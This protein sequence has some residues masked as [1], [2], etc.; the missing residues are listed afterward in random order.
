MTEFLLIL[1]GII[2]VMLLYCLSESL[3]FKTTEYIVEADAMNGKTMVLLSDLHC[4]TFGRANERLIRAVKEAGPDLIV[5]SGDLINGKNAKEFDYAYSFLDALKKLKVPVYYSFGN[6]ELKIT[7]Y[8]DQK[9][10]TKYVSE[11]KK[12]CILINNAFYKTDTYA[13]YGLVL[14]PELYKGKI[15]THHK[16][17]KIRPYLG[18]PTDGEYTIMIA[19]DPSFADRYF[20][21]G[22][23]LVLS[24]HL[25]GGIVRIPFVGG[26]IS[27]RYSFFPKP[28]KG[29]YKHEG[30]TM[31]ISGGLG[32]HGIPFRFNNVPEIVKIKF[33]EVHNE[34]SGQT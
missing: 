19:H 20:H 6:H 7:K 4:K 17:L 10:Y 31:I 12:R 13:M 1:L 8:Q 26:V 33:T 29:I 11:V 3:R 22:A 14:P 34:S 16:S 28:D 9:A 18:K 25:H 21:W 5:I 2:V 32:W 27:P 23:N 30:H 15:K 24:G